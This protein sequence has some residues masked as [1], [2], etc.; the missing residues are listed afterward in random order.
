FQSRAQQ[1]LLHGL[2]LFLD[3]KGLALVTG[4]SG[5]GKS[6]TLRRFIQSLDEARF[7]PIHIPIAPTTAFGFLRNVN[8][9]LGLPA[10]AHAADLYAQVQQ[11]LVADQGPH[12]VL[13]LDDA[14]A[15]KPEWLDLLRRLTTHALDGEDRFSILVS[16]TEELVHTFRTPGLESLRSRVAFAHALRAMQVDDTHAY[17][18]WHLERADAPKNLFSDESVRIL[19]QASGGRPR[20]VNQLALQGLITA[21]VHGREKIDARF[22]NETL[23]EHPLFDNGS[24]A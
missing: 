15:C 11:H 8:R 4:A 20:R 19:F 13:V 18:A 14:E 1:A 7:R 21:A 17:V 22:L 3:V 16:G 23:A 9:A 24:A 6:I 2:S 10:R 5:V 12:V